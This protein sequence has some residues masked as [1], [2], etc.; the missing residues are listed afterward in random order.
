MSSDICSNSPSFHG[1]SLYL[2]IG[3]T[4]IKSAIVPTLPPNEMVEFLTSQMEHGPKREEWNPHEDCSLLE[5]IIEELAHSQNHIFDRV[6]ISITGENISSNGRNYRDWLNIPDNLAEQIESS[7]EIPTGS[8]RIHHDSLAWGRGVRFLMHQNGKS[9]AERIGILALGNAVAFSI[10]T[11]AEVSAVDINNDVHDWRSF[12]TETN[13]RNDSLHNQLGKKYFDWRESN[14]ADYDRARNTQ[15]RFQIVLNELNRV[16][17]L[18]SFIFAGG[19]ARK[20]S[21]C[22]FTQNHI[23]LAD[24]SVGFSPGFIPLLGML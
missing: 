4:A 22:Q 7:L 6:L 21:E 10:I 19:N 15:S 24:Q 11:D 18:N 17:N 14:L 1:N 9:A 12:R 2:D 23:I 3:G 16:H 8:T 13:C 20:L 5:R